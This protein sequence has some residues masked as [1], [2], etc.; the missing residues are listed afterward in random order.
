MKIGILTS[1][2]D[3]PGMN[4]FI[5]RFVF[6]AKK[7]HE[8]VAFKYGYQGLVDGI[9]TS[10]DSQLLE[11]FDHLGGSLI[12]NSRCEEFKTKKGLKKALTTLKLYQIDCLVVLG[13][14]GTLKG[15]KELAKSNV[16]VI[17]VPSTIDNDLSLTE[18]TLGFD[19][20]VNAAVDSIDKIKQTMVSHGRV[21]ICEVMGRRCPDI[22]INTG[23]ATDASM[24]ITK[25]EQLD[26]KKVVE[27]V[28]ED[29]ACGKESPLIVIKE[30]LTDIFDLAKDIQNMIDIE[31]RACK[32]GYLQR[33]TA[34]SIFDRILASKFAE[35]TVK[36]INK[37][38]FN[39]IV[40]YNKNKVNLK[41]IL[42]N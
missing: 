17:Y 28:K 5:S 37:K 15:A 14:D 6:S 30:N 8:I 4:T 38:S 18:T 1:G 32:I 31:T 27:K 7:N 21:F 10:L 41:N 33:G 40:S 29:L 34:P 23:I 2:G 11:N 36:A 19:S 42:E 22:A 13:G 20:A 26:L 3:A 12:K 9:T 16:K 35:E 39:K 24:T 25:A